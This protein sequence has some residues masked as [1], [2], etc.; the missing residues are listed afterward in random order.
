MKGTMRGFFI[1][2]GLEVAGACTVHW[3]W[4][5]MDCVGGAR[6]LRRETFCRDTDHRAWHCSYTNQSQA[7]CCFIMLEGLLL[8]TMGLSL[9]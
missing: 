6:G 9:D 4:G 8:Q 7:I 2:A 5:C 3:L 1:A